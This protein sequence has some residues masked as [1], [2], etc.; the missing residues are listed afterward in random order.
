MLCKQ[1]VAGSNPATSTNHLRGDQSLTNLA[2][3]W[4]LQIGSIWVQ[5]KLLCSLMRAP[6]DAWDC[7][8]A[9][10]ET[11]NRIAILNPLTVRRGRATKSRHTKES[12]HRSPE[13]N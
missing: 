6:Q 3:A 1:G 2:Y 10:T 11:A 12:E 4:T 8:A 5:L 9:L 7:A 13:I